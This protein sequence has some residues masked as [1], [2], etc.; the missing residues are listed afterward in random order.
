MT[1]ERLPHVSYSGFFD[2]KSLNPGGYEN[3]KK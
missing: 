3:R 2:H 1:A